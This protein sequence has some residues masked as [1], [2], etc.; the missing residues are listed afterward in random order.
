MALKAWKLNKVKEEK[1]KID[2][3]Y[4][5]TCLRII[6]IIRKKIQYHS[7]FHSFNRLWSLCTISPH[8][9]PKYARRLFCCLASFTDDDNGTLFCD[10]WICCCCCLLL[11]FASSAT[12]DDAMI[13]AMRTITM[14]YFYRCMRDYVREK[15][16]VR[17]NILFFVSSEKND[18]KNIFLLVAAP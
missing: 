8:Y 3:N 7:L 14:L 11:D 10:F 13:M 18:M 4:R 15:M 1:W 12:L 6:M 9:S 16:D 17:F 2:K 5:F